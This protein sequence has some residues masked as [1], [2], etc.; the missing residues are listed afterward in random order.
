MSRRVR[1]IGLLASGEGSNVQAVI[2]ACQAG[3][4]PAE[5]AAL[6][7]NHS[8]SGALRRASEAG[9]PTYHLSMVTH[10]D[11]RSLD[12]AIR[13]AFLEHGVDVVALAG[14]TRLVGP[15]T[16]AAFPRR[17]FNIHPSLLPKYGGEGMFGLRVHQAVLDAGETVTGASVHIVDDEYDRGPVIAQV[18]TAVHVDDDAERLAKRML[19][20][21]H[22]LL[23]ATLREI[24]EGALEGG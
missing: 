20:L 9:I 10:P 8:K 13:D 23:V 15:A 17:I 24:C 7:S 5:V 11:P 21:E 12:E 6:I 4:I 18:E 3:E 14:Y 19:P 1:R 2:D 22:A 16:L